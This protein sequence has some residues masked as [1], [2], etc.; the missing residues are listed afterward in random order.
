[1]WK[2]SAVNA[3]NLLNI[4]T[5]RINQSEIC[6]NYYQQQLDSL[7]PDI[8][9]IIIDIFQGTVNIYFNRSFLCSITSSLK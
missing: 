6:S 7:D 5:H 2:D 9:Q 4:T 3:W 1:M 8:T